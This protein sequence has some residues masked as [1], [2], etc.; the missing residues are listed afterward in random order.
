MSPWVDTAV[1]RYLESVLPSPLVSHLSPL[2]LVLG[3][4]YRDPPVERRGKNG[5]T[6]WPGEGAGAG[7]GAE[8]LIQNV[9]T[10][11]VK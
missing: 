2:P 6:R 9:E 5:V 1:S 8:L 4:V 3:S 10:G 7:A 11:V